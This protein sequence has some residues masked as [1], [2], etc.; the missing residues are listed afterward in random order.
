M[1]ERNVI[2]IGGGGHAKVVINTLQLMD[3]VIVGIL[4]PKIISGSYVSGVK[5]L[6]D[7]KCI[8]NYSAEEIVLANGIGMIPGNNIRWEV[9]AHYNAEG[10]DFLS[11]LHPSA[12]VAEDVKLN[13]GVQIMAG[14]VIQ[15]G[16]EI[17]KGT[18]INTKTSI[19]HDCV[20]GD[21]C[22][23]A[24]GVTLSGNVE[25]GT[26]SFIGVGSTIMQDVTIGTNCVIGACS[27]VSKDI[28][29]NMKLIQ[30]R[31]NLYSINNG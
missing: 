26:K 21:K 30:S 31:D 4:D 27:I 9:Q 15:P 18:I 17:G 12:I 2:V 6:G 1:N 24:P 10:Y 14:V 20:I 29:S 16:V 7:D 11:L 19:D 28:K 22:H 13:A 5:V 3:C 8:K 23:L 25:I